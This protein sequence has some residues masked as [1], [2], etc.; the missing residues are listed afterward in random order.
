MMNGSFEEKSVWIQLVSVLAIMGGYFAIAGSMI[1]SGIVE[2]VA[3]VG[4]FIGTVVLLVMVLVAGHI[5]VAIVSRREDPDERD[6][7][8]EWRAES[9]TS[10][11]VPV[12]AIAAITALVFSIENLWVAHLLLLSLFVAEV[13]KCGLQLLFYRRGM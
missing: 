6:R 10:W 4:L 2:L 11:I 8:I 13:A 12:G 1:S 7:L 9:A 5:A 3:Y